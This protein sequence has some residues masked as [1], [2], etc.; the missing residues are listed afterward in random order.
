NAFESPATGIEACCG[1]G[2]TKAEAFMK[3]L[4]GGTN[5]KR[6]RIYAGV[7]T[8]ASVLGREKMRSL[9]GDIPPAARRRLLG[10]P[11]SESHGRQRA[12]RAPRRAG[13]DV[14]KAI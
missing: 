5:T 10:S 11:I 9:R 13:A 7:A 14:K 6:R 1:A 8:E 4:G 2:M 12:A 3:G